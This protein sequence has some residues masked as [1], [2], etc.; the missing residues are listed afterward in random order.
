MQVSSR[1]HRT[2]RNLVR[3]HS[4]IG[5]TLSCVMTASVRSSLYPLFSFSLQS[6]NFVSSLNPL[7]LCQLIFFCF[8]LDLD[9]VDHVRHAPSSVP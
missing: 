3:V 9:M 8:E 2:L 7:G 5:E 1:S 6:A 4:E